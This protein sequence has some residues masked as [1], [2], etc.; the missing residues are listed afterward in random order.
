[1]TLVKNS[2]AFLSSFLFVLLLASG[3]GA[4]YK[5]CK[6]SFCSQKSYV[7]KSSVRKVKV[8][9]CAKNVKTVVYTDI[10]SECFYPVTV[11]ENNCCSKGGCR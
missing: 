4:A 7:K 3:C 11:R 1:L 8:S 2:F 6:A 10:C 5:N 9:E